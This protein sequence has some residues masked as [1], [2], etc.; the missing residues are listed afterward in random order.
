MKVDKTIEM[1]DGTLTFQGELTGQELDMVIMYGLNTLLALG[2]V[3]PTII[4]EDGEEEEPEQMTLDL[5]GAD[6][7]TLQ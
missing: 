1:P 4:N 7:S 5:G 2:V 6:G 3:T